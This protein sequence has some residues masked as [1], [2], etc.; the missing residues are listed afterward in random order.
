[1]FPECKLERTRQVLQVGPGD[2]L[3]V[4]S[5]AH[6][7]GPL[8]AA[9]GGGPARL[10]RQLGGALGAR[11]AAAPRLPEAEAGALGGAGRRQA[12]LQVGQPRGHRARARR[13]HERARH[14]LRA[15][16]ACP[17]CA[18]VH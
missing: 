17:D 12:R 2:A 9:R 8:P 11:A 14:R 1:M 16:P 18:S 3:R 13:R 10:R 4:A 15:P 6:D 7:A 5:L